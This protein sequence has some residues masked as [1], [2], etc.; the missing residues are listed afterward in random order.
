MISSFLVF[1]G[2]VLHFSDLFMK[3]LSMGLTCANARMTARGRG[4]LLTCCCTISHSHKTSTR[5]RVDWS[6]GT[7]EA[8]L[9]AT[10][11]GATN[12]TPEVKKNHP[13]RQYTSTGN[14]SKK[15]EQE[16]SKNNTR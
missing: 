10:G 2:C 15:R 5:A 11:V 3:E 1:F 14:H 9:I 7:E 13:E 12:T 8:A 6:A 16:E 4:R